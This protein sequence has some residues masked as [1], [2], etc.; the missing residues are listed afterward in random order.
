MAIGELKRANTSNEAQVVY[1]ASAKGSW[2]IANDDA[3]TAQAATDYLNPSAIDE[4]TFHWVKLGPG[5]TRA[6]IR[7]RY[8]V[9]ATVTTSP[10][11]VPVLAY[12]T[13][14]ADGSMPTDGTVR[15]LRADSADY[16]ADGLTLTLVSS[17]TGQM[18]D[19]TYAYSDPVSL[20]ATDLQGAD[21]L[22]CV[23]RTAANV[24]T[25]AVAIEVLLLN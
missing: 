15:F 4:S 1:A 3:E 13:A 10:I 5:V 14:N 12:G 18:V 7:A 19:A 6:I 23:V 24:D 20:T 25:G 21:Y 22:G 16:N 17:G 11:F 8:A 2:I 9:G